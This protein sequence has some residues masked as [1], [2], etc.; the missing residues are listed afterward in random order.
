MPTKNISCSSVL[1]GVCV[2]TLGVI[3]SDNLKVIS[4]E[5]TLWGFSQNMVNSLA[6]AELFKTFSWQNLHVHYVKR[7]ACLQT[8]HWPY[9][10]SYKLHSA[11]SFAQIFQH[12]GMKK[13]E[14]GSLAVWGRN[15][16]CLFQG[17]SL[18]HFLRQRKGQKGKCG[19]ILGCNIIFYIR[20]DKK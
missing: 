20:F 10:M 2:W 12:I 11:T 19:Q 17:A 15:P 14:D 5:R 18:G 7:E 1:V 3:I 8:T 16:L 6:E 13:I 9:L 4:R